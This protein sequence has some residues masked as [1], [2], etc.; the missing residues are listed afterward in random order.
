MTRLESRP[1]RTALWEYVF[2]VDI[3]GHQTDP[4]VARALKEI[5]EKALFCKVLGSYPQSPL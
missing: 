5:G 4:A 1:S 3:E 2:F